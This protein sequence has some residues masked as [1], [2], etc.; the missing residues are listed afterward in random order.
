M[1]VEFEAVDKVGGF[2]GTLWLNGEN[3]GVSL[4]EQGF[5]Q[6]HGYSA[7]QSSY[8]NQ[9]YAAEQRAKTAQLNVSNL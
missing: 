9:L 1:E 3:F 6:V 7:D 5:A 8:G 4:L 2:I